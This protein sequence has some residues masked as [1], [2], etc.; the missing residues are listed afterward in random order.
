MDIQNHNV[1]HMNINEK[2][3]QNSMILDRNEQ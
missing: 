3:L 1:V 2:S